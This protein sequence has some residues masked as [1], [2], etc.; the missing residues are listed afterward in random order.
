MAYTRVWN[1]NAVVGGTPAAAIDTGFQNFRG[2]LTERMESKFITSMTAD[3]WVVKPEILGNVGSKLMLI[4]HSAFEPSYYWD[5][6]GAVSSV[7]RTSL[8]VEHSAGASVAAAILQ[9]PL[10]LPIG[11]SII[12]V[13]FFVNR[14]GAVNFTSRLLYNS[15]VPATTVIGSAVTS[16]NGFT[17]I[18]VSS[19]LP[20][21]VEA[22]RFYFLDVSPTLG[23]AQRLYG[24]RIRYDTPDCRNTL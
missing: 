19:G 16:S 10:I 7:T 21:V 6:V 15:L 13:Q 8:Y 14:N 4:H 12:D 22:E 2:D 20:H 17:N 23:S 9:A 3:P 24:A 5:A 11:V 1:D 18:V